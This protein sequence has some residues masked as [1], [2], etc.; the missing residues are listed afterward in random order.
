LEGLNFVKTGKLESYSEQ[1]LVDCSKN[2]NMGC[3]GGLM[4]YAFK[5]V[6]DNGIP[7]ESSYPYTARDGV[8]KSVS[9]EKVNTSFVDVP[10]HDP[11]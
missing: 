10:R 2:G 3:N 6:E 8:C 1:Y 11:N 9:T 5:Y 7:L 4:D